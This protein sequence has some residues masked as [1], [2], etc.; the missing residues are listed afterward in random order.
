MTSYTLQDENKT[1]EVDKIYQKG[2]FYKVDIY[3]TQH[4]RYFSAEILAYEIGGKE[5]TDEW[6]LSFGLE[7][8]AS[9]NE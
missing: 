4:G 2:V 9:E 1:I 5:P 8:Y 7:L 3:G 6:L